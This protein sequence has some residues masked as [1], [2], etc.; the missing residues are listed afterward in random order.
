M[1]SQ[2]PRKPLPVRIPR[3]LVDRI[4]ALRGLIPRETFIRELL[5]RAVSAEERKKGEQ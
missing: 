3:A 2:P 5:D 4:D 1:T